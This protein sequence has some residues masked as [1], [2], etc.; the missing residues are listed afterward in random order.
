[1]NLL[2]VSLLE[3]GIRATVFALAGILVYLIMRRWSPAAGSLTAASTLV[4]M[5][6]VS[7]LALNPWPRWAPRFSI[8]RLHVP[9]VEAMA[10]RE[11]AAPAEVER[12]ARRLA[13]WRSG[14]DRTSIGR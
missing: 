9:M 11:I 10:N 8:E 12:Y 4:V 5:G 3:G 13:L 14:T 1:M 7:L 6:I 2:E